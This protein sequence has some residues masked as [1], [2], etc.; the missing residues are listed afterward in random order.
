VRTLTGSPPIIIVFRLGIPFA[1]AAYRGFSADVVVI[2]LD[3]VLGRQLHGEA[4]VPEDDCA[5]AEAAILASKLT[6]APMKAGATV[7]SWVDVRAN[8][9]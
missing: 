7:Q 4:V 5:A 9:P 1:I 3:V 2:L 6:L 8:P